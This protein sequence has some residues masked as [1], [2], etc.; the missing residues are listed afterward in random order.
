MVRLLTLL[1]SSTLDK[2]EHENNVQNHNKQGHL[3]AGVA[4]KSCYFLGLL[5]ITF[6]RK[7][8]GMTMASSFLPGQKQTQFQ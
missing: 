6:V 2:S 3:K 7:V 8:R 5:T 4:V 1:D